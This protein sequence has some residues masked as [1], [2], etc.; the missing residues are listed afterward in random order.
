MKLFTTQTKALNVKI[1]LNVEIILAK[2]LS[3]NICSQTCTAAQKKITGKDLCFRYGA[4]K[5][6]ELN[7]ML[8]YQ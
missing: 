3:K 4:E 2:K 5:L 6:S 7:R 1:N 8:K